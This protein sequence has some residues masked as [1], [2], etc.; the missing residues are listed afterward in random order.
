MKTL[1]WLVI[2]A[3]LSGS[4]T[5]TISFDTAPYG[6]MPA[7]WTAVPP[8]SGAPCKWEVLKDPTAPTQPYVFAQVSTDRTA[9]RFPLAI[10]DRPDVRDGELSVKFKPVS[11]KEDQAAG[12][13]F[14]YRDPNNYYVVRANALEKNVVVYRVQEGRRIPLTPKGRPVNS[15]GVAHQ[16]RPN[17]WNILKFGLHDAGGELGRHRW[18]V[19]LQRRER[20]LHRAGHAV[21]EVARHLPDLHERA[22]HVPERL[23]H[24]GRGAQLVRLARAR[25]APRGRDSRGGP[26][27]RVRRARA[28]RRRPRAGRCAWRSP[29]AA[30][31]DARSRRAARPAAT[32]V[33]AMAAGGGQSRRSFDF[34]RASGDLRESTRRRSS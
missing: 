13:V 33:P 26:V 20:G 15:F 2:L 31:G 8:G 22:L 11:G 28:G 3:S 29:V 9:S 14:R 25:R 32:A 23:D 6:K 10:L 34:A 1:S 7:G 19:L 4:G 30:S 12:L 18:C 16:V 21:V 5:E 27:H 24:L 17:A